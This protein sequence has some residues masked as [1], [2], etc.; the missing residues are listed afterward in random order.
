MGSLL[1]QLVAFV[2]L[3]PWKLA[4]NSFGYF[5]YHAASSLAWFPFSPQ[6]GICPDSMRFCSWTVTF[7]VTLHNKPRTSSKP[8]QRNSARWPF[9]PG[10]QA[11]T[12]KQAWTTSSAETKGIIILRDRV[13]PQSMRTWK[14]HSSNL[15]LEGGI[16]QPG[17]EVADS[18]GTARKTERPHSL[19]PDRR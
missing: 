4:P 5:A 17:R 16:P 19:G 18:Q 2:L 13:I 14:G 15:P 1:L 3:P 8:P 6:P 7:L 9:C 11:Q 10:Q 12:R